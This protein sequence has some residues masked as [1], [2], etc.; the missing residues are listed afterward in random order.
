MV[1]ERHDGTRVR[2]FSR[3]SSVVGDDYEVR[4]VLIAQLWAAVELLSSSS[5]QRY[6]SG[7]TRSVWQT[8]EPRVQLKKSME[9]MKPLS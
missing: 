8:R 7:K 9:L 4:M 3:R 6:I 1:L 2:A 5:Y